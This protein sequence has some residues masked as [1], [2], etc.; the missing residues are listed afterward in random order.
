MAQTT[1]PA[2]HAS[3]R[4][5]ARRTSILLGDSN[6]KI[7][8]AKA[9]LVVPYTPRTARCFVRSI[10]TSCTV[11]AVAAFAA[12]CGDNDEE[13]TSRAAAKPAAFAIT[14]TARPQ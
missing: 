14:A 9:P 7:K 13:K 10:V 8:S 2:A 5:G 12:G 11:V 1:H 3:S 4:S 6:T